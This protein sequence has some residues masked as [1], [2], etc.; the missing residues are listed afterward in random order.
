MVQR[1]ARPPAKLEGAATKAAPRGKARAAPAS[2]AAKAS[3]SAPRPVVKWAGGKWKLLERLAPRVPPGRFGTYAEPFAGGAA[4]FFS[5]ADGARFERAR[6]ADKNEE[7]IS[8]YRAIKDDV[9]ALV[10][11]LR[12]IATRYAAMDEEARSELFYAVRQ[13]TTKGMSDAERGARLLFLNKTCFNGL[14][15]VN[16]KG[17]FNVPFGRYDNPRILDE[18]GLRAAH[19]ALQH[20]EIVNDDF[21]ALAGGLG[22]GD[23]VYFDPPYVPASKTANFTSYAADGFGAPEQERLA[24]TMAELRERGV[25]A[26]L[27]NGATPEAEELYARHDLHVTR[28]LAPRSINSDP[29]KR[30]DVAELVVTTYD[31][32][33]RVRTAL[34]VSRGSR[35]SRSKN[36]ESKP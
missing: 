8:L 29:T 15:R 11:R 5:L 4:M 1:A 16:S 27:S 23:F 28:I 30:G 32:A 7:L 25:R 13:K 14:W 20:A 24:S 18:D 19:L 21:A 31:E 17:V 9:S 35:G 6:L 26:M 22:P 2:A 34:R 12:K 36:E 33:F 10:E 3:S